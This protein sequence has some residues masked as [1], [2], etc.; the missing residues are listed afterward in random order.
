ML[1]VY[2]IILF[3]ISLQKLIYFFK[4]ECYHSIFLNLHLHFNIVYCHSYLHI[5]K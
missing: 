4:Q 2:K 5:L 3:A 1:Y